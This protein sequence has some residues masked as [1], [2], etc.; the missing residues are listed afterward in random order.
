MKLAS[1]VAC[2]LLLASYSLA[3]PAAISSSGVAS[4]LA[5]ASSVLASSFAAPSAASSLYPAVSASFSTAGQPVSSLVS[6]AHP[7]SS[8][9]ASPSSAS[10]APAAT[11]TVPYASEDG[12]PVM[13]GPDW[14]GV[15]VPVR[16]SLGGSIMGPQNVPMDLQNPDLLA[17]PSTDAGTVYVWF[18]TVHII[19]IKFRSP[20]ATFQRKCKVAVQSEPQPPPD[21]RL[22]SPTEQSVH[23]RAVMRSRQ[24]VY[25][26]YF[27]FVSR[28]I[29]DGDRDGCC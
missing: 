14:D 20:L 15:P 19:P 1:S 24:V 10:S 26:F 25:L 23:A 3:A 16:G 8:S 18:Y 6:A 17:P 2:A 22:G 4:S 28:R 29:A 27:I 9:K 5:P 21:R 7:S 11:E 13:W 12:N